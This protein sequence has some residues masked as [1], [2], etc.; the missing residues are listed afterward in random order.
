M[1]NNEY[2][3]KILAEQMFK[4]DDDELK[5]LRKWRQAI[6][7][8]LREKYAGTTISI[9]WAGAMAKGTM[10]R[11]S[12][13]GDVTIYFNNG[14][15][16]AG[17]TLEDIFKNVAIVLEGDYIVDR[18][19]SALRVREKDPAT[20]GTDTHVD[21]VPGRFTDDSK[22]TVYIHQ[23]GG[24]KERLKTNLDV[25]VEH[26]RDSGVTDAIRLMKLWNVRNG[27]A[28]KTFVLELLV[29]KL[30]K[31]KKSSSLADQLTHVW[32]QF[33]DHADDLAVEDPAN[34]A[35]NDLKPALDACRY[36]LSSVARSTLT[37]IDALGWESVFGAP[38]KE[39]CKE[40]KVAAIHVAVREAPVPTRPWCPGK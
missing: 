30:L 16:T 22:T 12:Y 26:I 24:T 21:V 6:E 13:D 11:Q 1:T 14:D 8:L 9:R 25:H 15:T 10:I 18:K 36:N 40:S 4:E 34:P 31:S 19:T 38:K 7:K 27:I 29:V 35:G 39:E 3:K 32:T 23:N 2:L 37:N 5:K 20:R 17:E 33:R 28:A